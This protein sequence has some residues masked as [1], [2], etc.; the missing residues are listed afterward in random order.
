MQ[1]AP[2]S[3]QLL[4]LCGLT[5]LGMTGCD[6]MP[7]WIPFQGPISDSLPGVVAPAERMAGL[8]KL[9]E[10]APKATPE[11]KQ[12]ISNQLA[13]S[14]RDEKD[15]L[16][17][18]KI[19]RVLG[20]YP[21]VSADAVLKAAMNDPDLSARVAACEAWGRHHDEQAV[22]LLAAAMSGDADSDVRLAAARALGETKS[23]AAVKPLGDALNDADPAL[24]WRAVQA[25]K[26]ITG[27]DLGNDVNRWQQYV[28]GETPSPP[29]LA[30]RLGI[31]KWF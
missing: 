7:T 20:V 15:P 26:R 4:V 12:L 27:K 22:D 28:R 6:V 17:R 16:I 1:I 25:L 2:R 18:E 9:L 29:T 19:I 24:Q 11:Q 31:G 3:W 10:D 21:S 30:E 5:A 23:P 14:I 13:N 8:D